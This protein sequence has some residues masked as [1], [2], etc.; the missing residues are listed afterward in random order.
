[1]SFAEGW[2][3]FRYCGRRLNMSLFDAQKAEKNSERLQEHLKNVV[4]DEGGEVTKHLKRL[5]DALQRQS[6]TPQA[7]QGQY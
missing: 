7:E 6:T 2:E 1:V 5:A 3:K 4:G